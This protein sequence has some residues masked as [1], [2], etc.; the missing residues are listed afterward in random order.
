MV[1]YDVETTLG[2]DVSRYVLF[3][4]SQD[5]ESQRDYNALV[6]GNEAMFAFVRCGIENGVGVAGSLVQYRDER[7]CDA[8]GN[9]G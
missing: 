7:C 9:D 5:V 1:A 2:N 6:E 3:L 4:K 8:E